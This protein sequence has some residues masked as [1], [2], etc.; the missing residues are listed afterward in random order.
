MALV[1][2]GDTIV[3]I[4]PW[5]Q[6]GPASETV[7]L[8]G[9]AVIPAAVNGHLHSFQSLLRGVADNLGFA[10]WRDYLYRKTPLLTAD[11]VELAALFA[12]SESALRGTGTVCDFF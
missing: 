11:G 7:D 8:T 9:R 4:Q 2:E 10:G 3:D 12:Y 1:V 5:R 6:P